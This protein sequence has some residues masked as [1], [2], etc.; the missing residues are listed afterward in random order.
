[1]L[2]DL[3]SM[4]L[5]N[6][7]SGGVSADIV[8]EARN[9]VLNYFSAPLDEYDCVFTSGSTAGLKLIGEL[10]PWGDHGHLIHPISAHT[11]LLGMRGYANRSLCFDSSLL[12]QG[13]ESV[14][15]T[16]PS[17][18]AA[19]ATEVPQDVTK[20]GFH[21]FATPGECNFSGAKADLQWASALFC[22]YR[23]GNGVGEE[24]AGA[25][26]DGRT[27]K[28]ATSIYETLQNRGWRVT[29]VTDDNDGNGAVA[30]GEMHPLP[31]MWL[32]DAAK[33]AAT[34]PV[35]LDDL[36]AGARPDFVT[37]SFYKM[38]GY[39][40]GL[41]AL[42]VRKERSPLLRLHKRYF[43]GGTVH[44]L[45]ATSG[46]VMPRELPHEYM[47]D[48][49]SHYQGISALRHCFK[50]LSDCGGMGTVAEELGRLSALL[51]QGMT[52]LQHSDGKPVCE[53]Y[54]PERRNDNNVD[55]STSALFTTPGRYCASRGPTLAFNL[56]WA[57][58]S[59]VG[60]NEVHRI[61]CRPR[62]GPVV[63]LRVGCFCNPGGCQEALGLSHNQIRD[64]FKAGRYCWSEDVD[65]VE[66]LRT[67]AV[68]VSLG[69]GSTEHDVHAFLAFLTDHYVDRSCE[70]AA[71]GR[72][73]VSERGR[74]VGRLLQEKENSV[75]SPTS[76]SSSSSKAVVA[77]LAGMYVYPIKSCA[78]IR[79]P[80]WL[81]H[82]SSGLVLD[83][84]WVVMDTRTGRAVTQKTCPKMCLLRTEI[85][86]HI[87]E[88]EG[89]DSSSSS[90]VL[91]VV[92]TAPEEL[93]RPG[94]V[95]LPPLLLPLSSPLV[96]ALMKGGCV[97]YALPLHYREGVGSVMIG[98]GGIIDVPVA[99]TT[100][101]QKQ[102]Q[103]DEYV[104]ICAQ[105]R[106]ARPTASDADLWFSRYLEVP[107]RL[108]RREEG[109]GNSSAATSGN[110]NNNNNNNNNMNHHDKNTLSSSS[111]GGNVEA[112]FANEA[113]LLVVNAAS[114]RHLRHI[115]RMRDQDESALGGKRSGAI[116]VD[117]ESLPSLPSSSS[118]SSSSSSA[119]IINFRPNLVVEGPPSLEEDA[120]RCLVLPVA[121]APSVSSST[122][123]DDS[124]DDGGGSNLI[125]LA[126]DKPCARCSVVNVNVASGAMDGRT[127][128]T[129]SSFRKVGA[130]P[131]FGLFLSV[132]QWP[133]SSPSRQGGVNVD[134]NSGGNGG[135]EDHEVLLVEENCCVHIE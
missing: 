43:G 79:V 13:D 100:T 118:S 93:V 127:L 51:E 7:H 107:C 69:R 55:M 104:K 46:F 114:V 41:G 74:V 112:S 61:A 53:I 132:G 128:S 71:M 84:E 85:F 62:V 87:S 9:L 40:T 10:F 89:R 70:D 20:G 58:G 96:P 133:S 35:S 44:A 8:T 94:E 131:C 134:G 30:A 36:P 116:V 23:D 63:H 27:T 65:L 18:A 29:D 76:S 122:S 57:D 2:A 1:V 90:S 21:L 135:G 16:P 78:G 99:T 80:R 11:S 28:A 48:G 26:G 6:P 72:E 88:K 42:L 47:E 19:T 37:V 68:R 77:V 45:A 109:A 129:L 110:N 60:H 121:G 39:P 86:T 24:G 4:S 98:D 117:N 125:R 119:D 103:Q 50:E 3:E 66:G 92:V 32:L 105:R 73:I 81:L 5:G 67:G 106:R 126:V 124:G 97:P 59:P 75:V 52:A 49:T 91:V 38:F 33:L 17:A 54:T 113:P 12:Y 130:S 123:S 102:K 25:G 115:M 108:L 101:Q 83:R 34:S 82:K 22:S 64:N 15:P 111:S 14:I 120:W 56:R 95:S 31:W